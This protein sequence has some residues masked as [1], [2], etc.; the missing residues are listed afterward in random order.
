MLADQSI[1]TNPYAY[2][3]GAVGIGFIIGRAFSGK[4]RGDLDVLMST[5]NKINLGTITGLLGLK[6]DTDSTARK[7]PNYNSDQARKIG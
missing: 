1:K 2:A 6:S 7:Q 3:L 4:G 5:V